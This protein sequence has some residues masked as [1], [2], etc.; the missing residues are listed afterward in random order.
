MEG[1][2]LRSIY[3]PLENVS[4]DK[5]EAIETFDYNETVYGRAKAYDFSETWPVI[6][7]F[8]MDDE[9]RLWCQPL[10]KVTAPIYG[11]F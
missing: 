11:G 10:R 3:Y 8:L 7:Q 4:F 9:N 6:D 2:Y 1:E 5:E